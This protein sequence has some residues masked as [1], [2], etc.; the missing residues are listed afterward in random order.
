MGAPKREIELNIRI[1]STGREESATTCLQSPPYATF[2][3]W[4]HKGTC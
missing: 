4:E 3:E 1:G 2:P